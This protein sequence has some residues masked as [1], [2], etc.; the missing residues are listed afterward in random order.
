MQ[1][2]ADFLDLLQDTGDVI[3]FQTARRQIEESLTHKQASLSDMESDALIQALIDKGL[4]YK[5]IQQLM[6]KD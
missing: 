6:D 5:D 3:D 1:V 4:S 2:W